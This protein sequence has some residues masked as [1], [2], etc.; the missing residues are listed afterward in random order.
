MFIGIEQN[1]NQIY[2]LEDEISNLMR[3]HSEFYEIPLLQ[4]TSK[5]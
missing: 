4:L 5:I 3:I 2:I 1:E